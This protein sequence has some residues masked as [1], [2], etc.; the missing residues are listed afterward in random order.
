MN[1][2]LIEFRVH[3]KPLPAI[4][5]QPNGLTS[6]GDDPI[7]AGVSRP[8]AMVVWPSCHPSSNGPRFD[9]ASYRPAA[10]SHCS[11]VG[12]WTLA[13][14]SSKLIGKSTSLLG[15]DVERRQ[16]RSVLT[17]VLPKCLL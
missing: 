4:S 13:L 5:R 17:L 3:S 8:T 10:L 7:G 15:C 12:S 1:P 2:R 6:A 9:P 11:I 14:A 16:I